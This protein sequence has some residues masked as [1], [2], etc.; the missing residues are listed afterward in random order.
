[1]ALVTE[2]WAGREICTDYIP[3]QAGLDRRG[4]RLK[5]PTSRLALAVLATALPV[6]AQLFQRLFNPEVDVRIIH[7]PG[8]GIPVKR[9]AFLPAKDARTEELTS[10]LIADLAADGRVELLDR[11][12]LDRILSEQKF[13]QSGLVD[14]ASAVALG[15]LLGSPVLLSVQVH[16]FQAREVPRESRFT[17]RD[18]DGQARTGVRY[19]ART[20][21]DLSASVQAVDSATGRIYSSRRLVANPSLETTSLQGMPAFPAKSE[22]KDLALRE[23]CPEVRRML[24]S[25]E[26]RRRL[27]FYDDRDYGMKEAYRKLQVDDVRGALARSLEAADLAQADA[28]AKPKHRA[29]TRYNLGICHFIL[30]DYGAALPHLKAASEAEPGHGIFREALVECQRALRLQTD[31]AKVEARGAAV[32]VAET[33]VK[34]TEPA[35]KLGGQS[36]EERLERLERLKA[37]GLVSPEEYRQRRAELLKEL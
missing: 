26:E 36:L 9:V 3:P 35:D 2:G 33:P 5:G 30:G 6:Q 24:L 11:G 17:Y 32:S 19:T 23:V 13:T 15:Q 8:L 21:V 1:M 31:M 27:V 25:W 14:E 29:R 20:Q 34:R 22:V 37:K 18:E 28:G 4:A 16:A 12:N 10:A 7:P